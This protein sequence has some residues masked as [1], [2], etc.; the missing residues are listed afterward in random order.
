MRHIQQFA[1]KLILVALLSGC[2]TQAVR[3]PLPGEPVAD[4]IS[5]LRGNFVPGTQPDG[6]TV[7][8]RG[9]GGLVVVDTGRHAA[10][11]ARIIEAARASGQPVAA[12]V[13]THWHLDHVA[14]NAALREAFPQL[15][16]HASEAIDQALHG[17][18]ADYRVQLQALVAKP[19]NATP[20]AVAGWR[21]EIARIDTGAQL[22]PTQ[23]V[24][25]SGSFSPG[26]RRLRLGLERNAVSG[27]DVWLF[28]PATRTLV[29][30]DL[31]TLP[32]PLFDTACSGGWQEALGRLD[33][34]GFARL[35]PGHGAVMDHAQFGV[36]RGA[37]D[38]LLA[39]AEGDAS[40]D[41]CKAG[42]LH[43]A[44]SLIPPQ[45]VALADPLLDYY[46]THVLR[47]DPVRRGKY[48]HK[49]PHE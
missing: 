45:D 39:C 29:A 21:G 20:A 14:G 13:N 43:D 11:A 3:A 26:G 23:P 35:V 17:F 40:A 8:L 33:G 22:R 41:A 42:W 44:Q 4:E 25:A 18:L 31:V 5:L 49:E 12:I 7:L 47:A 6:N 2:A 46:I 24:R 37:F 19:G 30:G 27:G 16:V 34:I 28:D 36:Y 38:R 1:A 9:R 32:V 10:H 15:Q 48:C